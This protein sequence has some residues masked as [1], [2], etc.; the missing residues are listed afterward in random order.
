MD[1][2]RQTAQKK[3]GTAAGRVGGGPPE[4]IVCVLM[5]MD[6]QPSPNN[7]LLEPEKGDRVTMEI[8]T[9]P[10]PKRGSGVL[11]ICG[12]KMELPENFNGSLQ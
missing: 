2:D 12:K 5:D 9:Q 4:G 3:F 1:M 8:D 11:I 10:P 6:T 7:H